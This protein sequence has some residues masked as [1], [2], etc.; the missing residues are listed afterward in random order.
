MCPPS[1]KPLL[2]SLHAVRVTLRKTIV[3]HF[4]RLSTEVEEFAALLPELHIVQHT[5]LNEG[6]ETCLVNWVSLQ[7]KT[8]NLTNIKFGTAVADH[9]IVNLTSQPNLLA[10][11]CI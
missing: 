5:C 3:V 4:L 9:K 8:I 1:S 10:L 2:T 7:A 6:C 11:Q